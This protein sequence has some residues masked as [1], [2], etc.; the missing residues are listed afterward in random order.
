MRDLTDKKKRGKVRTTPMIDLKS[1]DREIHDLSK[2]L[3]ALQQLKRAYEAV[4]STTPLLSSEIPK[5][6]HT[7]SELDL[8]IVKNTIREIFSKNNN[9]A[10]KKV[11]IA[12]AIQTLHPNFSMEKIQ[13]KLTY[14]VQPD[15]GFFVKEGYGKY[16]LA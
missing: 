12:R 13:E 7:Q 3:G 10:M 11:E 8:D 1:I 6:L 4:E 14:L 2:K 9:I 5:S 16:K 15:I